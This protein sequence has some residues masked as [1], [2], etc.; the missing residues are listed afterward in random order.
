MIWNI[1][2]VGCSS[3]RTKASTH[4]EKHNNILEFGFFKNLYFS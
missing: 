1:F 4:I 2:I 3:L